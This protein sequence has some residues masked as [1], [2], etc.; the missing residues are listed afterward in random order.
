[1]PTTA[2]AASDPLDGAPAYGVDLDLVDTET[3]LFAWR[4]FDGAIGV[5]LALERQAWCD[6]GRP[7]RIWVTLCNE[8]LAKIPSHTDGSAS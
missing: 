7:T 5:S 1:M 6:L 3:A 8:P 2:I 4:D